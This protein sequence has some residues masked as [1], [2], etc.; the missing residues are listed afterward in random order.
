MSS[1]RPWLWWWLSFADASGFKGVAIVGPEQSVAGAALQA[2]VLGI[3]PGGE[4]VGHP[5]HADGLAAIPAD[6]RKR[7]LSR[8]EAV[9]LDLHM[10]RVLNVPAPVSA[11]DR[12]AA[13]DKAIRSGA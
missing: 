8:A 9:A 10:G 2:H 6:L 4:V 1:N 11:E 3:N 7:L 12:A 5:I 13:T